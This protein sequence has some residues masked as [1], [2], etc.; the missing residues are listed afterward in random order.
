MDVTAVPFLIQNALL[1][2]D[3]ECQF[4]SYSDKTG[5]HIAVKC[6]VNV[7]RTPTFD[8][9]TAH[10]FSVIVV[11]KYSN[12]VVTVVQPETVAVPMLKHFQEKPGAAL[13]SICTKHTATDGICGV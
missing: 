11:S 5:H 1:H 9:C 12:N 6:N 3:R 10:V 2:R 7:S 4:L 8:P 13:G